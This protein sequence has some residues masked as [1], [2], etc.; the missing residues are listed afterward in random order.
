MRYAMP[1]VDYSPVSWSTSGIM[2][3]QKELLAFNIFGV[4][5]TELVTA[6]F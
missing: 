5:Y 3:A 4:Y 2:L 6:R 1:L